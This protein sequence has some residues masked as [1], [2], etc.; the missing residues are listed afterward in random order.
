MTSAPFGPWV[1]GLDNA[2]R[3]ARWRALTA[4]AAVYCGSNAAVV[5]A[6]CAA[7]RDGRAAPRA[8]EL[9]DAMPALRRRRLLSSY[10]A[11]HR[12]DRR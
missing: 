2:E 6:L 4:L 7:E 11:I 10:A 8:L 1:P 3:T 9:F 12:P 5:E